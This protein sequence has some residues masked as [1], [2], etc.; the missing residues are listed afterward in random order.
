MVKRTRRASKIN[1]RRKT[2]TRSKRGRGRGH[3]T[4]K[5]G[6]MMKHAAR[7]AHAAAAHHASRVSSKHIPHTTHKPTEQFDHFFG[8][9]TDPKRGELAVYGNKYF[10]T[11]GDMPRKSD[12]ENVVKGL[13]DE[14]G[15]P[16]QMFGAFT[17]AD[18][19]ATKALH[20]EKLHDSL[21]NRTP[22][23]R[24]K[25]SSYFTP[26]V[27]LESIPMSNSGLLE[28]PY[29]TPAGASSDLQS[30]PPPTT[31]LFVRG[32][33]LPLPYNPMGFAPGAPGAGVIR[34][35]DADFDMLPPMGP[36][37]FTA[38]PLS[39]Q[40]SDFLSFNP[41]NTFPRENRKNGMNRMNCNKT[42]WSP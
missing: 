42:S 37:A 15:N 35:L 12:L 7:T 30:P 8:Y 31:D 32:I 10:E 5:R 18:D 27:G 22:V 11:P 26:S 29:F 24:T 17:A 16:V 28:N 38:S 19:A 23:C 40:R 9:N 13:N 39:P 3:R 1:K 4:V 33:G 34:S 36:P 41:P 21:Q 25:S 14:F 6:G 2:N 20:N